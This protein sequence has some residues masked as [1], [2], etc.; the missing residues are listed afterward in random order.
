[1]RTYHLTGNAEGMCVGGTKGLGRT[2]LV[3]ISIL[4]LCWA[5]S[6]IVTS[7]S[8]LKEHVLKQVTLTMYVS[9]NSDLNTV[10]PH[11]DDAQQWPKQVQHGAPPGNLASLWE[12]CFQY[13]YF[14]LTVL[15]AGL[16]R[17]QA[18]VQSATRNIS[19][20]SRQPVVALPHRLQVPVSQTSCPGQCRKS[21][22][23][24]RPHRVCITVSV[25]KWSHVSQEVIWPC[26][27]GRGISPLKIWLLLSLKKCTIFFYVLLTFKSPT[28]VLKVQTTGNLGMNG[29]SLHHTPGGDHWKK[30]YHSYSHFAVD[31]SNSWYIR[32]HQ[33]GAYSW[34]KVHFTN[35]G[36]SHCSPFKYLYGDC[37]VTFP[38][39]V[40]WLCSTAVVDR[41]MSY[42]LYG[43]CG[44]STRC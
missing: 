13:G 19:R 9:G 29:S 44:A 36:C 28:S 8:L 38:F 30:A 21:H 20:K 12:D 14:R 31:A 15:F 33:W 27:E 35:T 40:A 32:M 11:G 42:P 3:L 2:I 4:Q 1:M 39:A 6:R 34:C 17:H 24:L 22:H 10:F 18:C 23:L 7:I 26:R 43:C 5:F 41:C 25:W 37:T 16:H